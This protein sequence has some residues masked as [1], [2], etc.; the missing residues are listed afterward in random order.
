M[1]LVWLAMCVLNMSGLGCSSFL[2]LLVMTVIKVLLAMGVV[3]EATGVTDGAGAG[4]SS[5]ALLLMTVLVQPV[6]DA[7]RMGV[8][9][10][11]SF[12]TSV[13]TLDLSLVAVELG[14]MSAGISS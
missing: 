10:G 3:D 14:V 1:M 5:L 8:G 9:L 6:M 2:G 4:S 13:T 12:L 11:S 7:L